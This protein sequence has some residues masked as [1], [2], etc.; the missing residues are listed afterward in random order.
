MF[1]S[2]LADCSWL[3]KN[4]LFLSE[5]NSPGIFEQSL[6][7]H[8]VIIL[9]AVITDYFERSSRMAYGAIL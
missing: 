2:A 7:R 9:K 3:P 4:I 6:S 1:I 8:F 5:S